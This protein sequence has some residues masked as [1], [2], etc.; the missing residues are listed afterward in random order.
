[1][2]RFRGVYVN[3]TDDVS[4][5]SISNLAD[6]YAEGAWVP[7][8]NF[9]ASSAGTHS[10]ATG[11]WIRT[12]R[13]ITCKFSIRIPTLSAATGN[14]TIS[15]LPFLPESVD[16]TDYMGGPVVFAFSAPTG[17]LAQVQPGVQ[18]I[19]LTNNAGAVLN[20]TSGFANGCDI[21]GYV[22]YMIQNGN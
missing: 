13:L 11:R 8:L 5:T 4:S 15:G 6:D 10:I 9:G 1:M 14:V 22:T 18:G 3:A 21:R 2:P 7:Q 19:Y 17:M 16:G 12:G 20:N